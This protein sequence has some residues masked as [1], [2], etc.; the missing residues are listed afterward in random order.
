MKKLKCY[1]PDHYTYIDA[2]GDTYYC[3]YSRGHSR[4]SILKENLE[5]IFRGHTYAEIREKL[6]GGEFPAGCF[7]CSNLE[8]SGLSSPRTKKE[9]VRDGP[10]RL[11]EIEMKLSNKCNFRCRM[12]YIGSSSRWA[13]LPE[14]QRKYRKSESQTEEFDQSIEKHLQLKPYASWLSKENHSLQNILDSMGAVERISF[15]GGEPLYQNE[16]YDFLDAIP[17][18]QKRKIELFYT[19]NLSML[20]FEGKAID[21][22]WNDFKSVEL[23][24]SAD[25]VYDV[26]DYIREGGKFSTLEKNL[27][28][29]SSW[30]SII[31]TSIN[32]TIQAYNIFQIPEITQYY[33]SE[34]P[35]F[36][37]RLA[38]LVN[39]QFLSSR[40]FPKVTTE[41]ILKRIESASY[42]DTTSPQENIDFIK[43][44]DLSHLYEK[45]MAYTGELDKESH[46]SFRDLAKKYDIILEEK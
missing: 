45:F 13:E 26:Y 27:K 43:S 38:H 21:H 28:T 1:Y 18:D 34:F 32:C 35:D 37:L 20:K 3:C 9:I 29:I 42:S 36:E 15:S 19:T 16:H 5:D 25:G 8:K 24:V 12:C 30:D 23:Q 17:K 11:Q 2:V 22:Y 44:E 10:P 46:T 31:R 4:G 41:Q 7:T 40:V 6:K 33:H 14:I 39:P